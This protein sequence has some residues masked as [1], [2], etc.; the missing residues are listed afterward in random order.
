MTT[1]LISLF[2]KDNKNV[3]SPKVR[4]KYGKLSGVV[5]I[6]ANIILFLAKLTV[7]LLTTSVSI[8]A[9]ALNNLSDSASS[10]ITLIGFKFAEKPADSEHPFGHGRYEYIAA[11]IISVF[12]FLMGFEIGMTSL[13][14]ILNPQ[15]ITFGIVPVIVLV[16]SILVKLWLFLFNRKI[17]KIINSP[18]MK[19]TA[20]DS[21]SD[22][23]STFAVIIGIVIY[24]LTS[25]NIDGYIGLLVAIL[26]F[27]SGINTIKET[28]TKLL[29]EA[30][31]EELINNITK[32]V[33]SYYQII[34]MHDL[35]VHNYGFGS[36]IISL[37]VEVPATSDFILI[38]DLIDTIEEDLNEKYNCI[39]VI[40]MDPV[41]NED[42][43]VLACK[44]KVFGI[45]KSIHKDLTIHDFRMVVGELRTNI[46]FDLVVPYDF[47]LKDLEVK[48]IVTEK[49]KDLDKKYYPKIKI[50]KG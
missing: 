11:F 25:I 1:L 28:I 40:H 18:A 2:I 35:I 39:S 42:E 27:I 10:I 23:F 48:A 3:S 26:I 36:C 6:V 12:I 8:I 22:C 49:I 17:G 7:G 47:M 5:G 13:D 38:H 4:G 43:N 31:D 24:S 37:H 29:G 50:D 30:P 14:K 41:A 15:E 21:L 34:G 33:L 16:A 46:I 19:A 44:E 9:D 20:A 45:I 32:D